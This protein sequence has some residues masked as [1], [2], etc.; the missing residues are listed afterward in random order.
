MI[1]HLLLRPT[2]PSQCLHCTMWRWWRRSDEGMWP[3]RCAHQDNVRPRRSA[4]F[5]HGGSAVHFWRTALSLV[6]YFHAILAHSD[7]LQSDIKNELQ[8]NCNASASSAV[9]PENNWGDVKTCFC[10]PRCTSGDCRHQAS[11]SAAR[12]RKHHWRKLF[13]KK[14]SRVLQFWHCCTMVFTVFNTFPC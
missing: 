13:F 8:V 2:R 1:L 5:S 9:R 11:S 4:M 12:T 7:V 10:V 14:L 6:G 3:L